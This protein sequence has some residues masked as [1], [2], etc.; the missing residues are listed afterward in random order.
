[1]LAN[2]ASR[3]AIPKGSVT[4]NETALWNEV[5]DNK[6]KETTYRPRLE[7]LHGC[8]LLRECGSHEL[9]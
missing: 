6:L 8:S 3:P 5:D 9:L 7:I 2:S 4:S 1:M